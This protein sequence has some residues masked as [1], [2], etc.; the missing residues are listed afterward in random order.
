MESQYKWKSNSR[1][2]V[3]VNAAADEINRIIKARGYITPPILL[4]E[5]KKERNPL[6]SCFE[7]NDTVAANM[8]REQQAGYIIRSIETV[9][10][11]GEDE[12]IRIRAFQSVVKEDDT[13]Y[14][15]V[16]QARQTPELWEQVV[17]KALLEIHN[18]RETYKN[19]K[20]FETI[21]DAID[22]IA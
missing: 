21:F 12:S 6:H 1:V 3:K 13:V 2:K 15:T 8:Y 5:A 19:I 14:V 4:A 18:W 20:E 17:A 22:Q 11:V 9:I 7:W 16:Q 10:D